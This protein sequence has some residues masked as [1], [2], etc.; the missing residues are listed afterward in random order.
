MLVKLSGEVVNILCDVNNRYIPFIV[1]ENYKKVLYMILTKSLYGCIQSAMLWYDTFKNCLE[2]TGF[3]LNPYDPCV[4]NKMI[5]TN[6]V[7]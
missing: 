5:I 7:R 3:K 6:S 1:M 4:A 2:N